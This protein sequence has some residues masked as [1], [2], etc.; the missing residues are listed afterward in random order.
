MQLQDIK[1]F[2]SN[3]QGHLVTPDQ[4]DYDDARS[5]FNAMIDK[6]PALIAYCASTGDVQTAVEFGQR[7]GLDT[8]IRGGGHSA[9][10][11]SLID[12]GLVIDLSLMKNIEVDPDARRVRVQTGCCWGEVDRATHAHGLATVSGIIST[13]GVPGLTLAGGHGY[14][15]RKYGLTVDN[16]R[17]A[18]VVLADGSVVRASANENADLLWALRGGGGNFGVVTEMEFQLHPVHTVIAGPMFWSLDDVDSTLR[19]YREWLPQA[20]RDTYAFYAVGRV[21]PADP[22][23]PEVQGRH[24]CGLL[25][26]HLGTEEDA[27]PSLEAARQAAPPIFEHVGPMPYPALQSTFDAFY[28]PGLQAYWK[29]DLFRELSDEAV[30][31]HVRF[32]K[33]PTLHSTMH[34]YPVNGAAH[35]VAPSDT[36]WVHRDANWSMVIVGVDPDPAN[37]SKIT[38]WAR[39]YWQALHP[40]SMGAAYLNFMM[41]EGAQRIRATYGENFDRLQQI[42]AKYDPENFFHVNHN[43]PPAGGHPG[44]PGGEK[45]GERPGVTL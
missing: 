17:G 35:E 1:R 16:L 12:D 33:V 36:P 22:F 10:G 21:P 2:A 39:D 11:L 19:W 28:P 45:P 27:R 13:T 41:E 18:E 7:F 14:L 38:R 40:H 34:L 24:M 20:P 43:I 4:A 29:G 15:T 42:K 44:R 5:L 9:P 8:A 25:W 6:R 37:A 26:C 30:A 32:A 23:P 31:Q 3:L